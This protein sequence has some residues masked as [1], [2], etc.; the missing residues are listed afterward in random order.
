MQRIGRSEP[1]AAGTQQAINSLIVTVGGVY[2]ATHS[3]TVTIVGTVASTLLIAWRLW[4]THRWPIGTGEATALRG[5]SCL[6]AQPPAA[7]N[8]TSRSTTTPTNS[9]TALTHADASSETEPAARL[10]P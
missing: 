6:A 10:P 4:L 1:S 3:V 8:F 9:A 7:S 2:L 5:R